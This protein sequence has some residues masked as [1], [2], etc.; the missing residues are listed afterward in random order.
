MRSLQEFIEKSQDKREVQ[1]AL[2]VK[3]LLCGYK[4]EQIMPILGVSSVAL[5]HALSV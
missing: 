5:P 4:H 3:I 2:A 1:R